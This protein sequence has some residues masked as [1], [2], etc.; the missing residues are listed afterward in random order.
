M[1]RRLGGLHV[2]NG[3]IHF[4][5]TWPQAAV[6]GISLLVLLVVVFQVG[7]RSNEPPNPRRATLEDILSGTTVAETPTTVAPPP[8][9]G[10]GRSVNPVATPLPQP[11]EDAAA[12]KP[13]VREPPPRR[14]PPPERPAQAEP[15]EA[16]TPVADSYYIVVQ[17]FRLRDQ[18]R[19]EAAQEFLR[20]HGVPCAI[21]T[22]ADLQLVATAPFSSEQQ[23]ENLRKRI[24]DVGKE[25]RESGGYDFA[26]A[27]ARKF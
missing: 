3:R 24:V 21:R 23:A 15:P 16:F 1:S 26:S 8:T 13:P 22:G 7:R 4:A 14:V 27:R 5:L 20:S 2:T 18:Q 19:A 12:A 11:S 17:H 6:V 10:H 9:P 25:Y